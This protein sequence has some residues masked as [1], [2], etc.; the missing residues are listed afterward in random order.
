MGAIISW[1]IF[2]FA[3]VLILMWLFRDGLVEYGDWWML[4][5]FAIGAVVLFPAQLQFYRHRE[6]VTEINKDILCTSCKYYNADEAL[7]TSL[8]QDVTE[9]IIPCEGFMWEPK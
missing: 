6:R 3:I 4:F 8:D 9:T 5:F 2:R 7:C 1:G